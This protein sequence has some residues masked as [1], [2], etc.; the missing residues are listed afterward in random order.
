MIKSPFPH[1]KQHHIIW[2]LVSNA[3]PHS[4][5]PARTFTLKKRNWGP[6]L[7]YCMPSILGI[8]VW[9]EGC[10]TTG[11]YRSGCGYIW[12]NQ[13]KETT[14]WSNYPS[15]IY[16]NI[17][18]AWTFISHPI[19]SW[20]IHPIHLIPSHTKPARTFISKEEEC[21]PL[22]S[23]VDFVF[24]KGW[25]LFSSLPAPCSCTYTKPP[26]WFQDR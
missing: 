25:A 3:I 4:T 17:V 24:S 10:T 22:E 6:C 5:K 20:P 16:N 9:K 18:K 2:T 7:I 21:S 12:Y 11:V 23:E 8:W 15:H 14:I 19:L 1:L 13:E 26:H